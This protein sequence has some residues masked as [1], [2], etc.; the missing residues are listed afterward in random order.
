MND[1]NR[2]ALRTLCRAW[3]DLPFVLVGATAWNHHI[4]LR[5]RQTHDLDV[6]IAVALDDLDAA[7]ARLPGWT[8]DPRVPHRWTSP[9]RAKV[10]VVPAGVDVRPDA[11]LT[12]PDSGAVMDLTG[13][14]L[15]FD[16][17]T[18][19]RL[20]GET[21][22]RVASLPSL[23]VLKAAAWLDRPDERERDL[24][25]LAHAFDEL[26][27]TDDPRRFDDDLLD[28]RVAWDEAGPWV[29]GRAVAAIARAPHRTRL[30]RFLDAVCDEDQ[31]HH[32][33]MRH[34][35]PAHWRADDTALPRRLGAFRRALGV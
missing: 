34:L 23:V 35:G 32:A 29:L 22:V 2:E 8:R 25:D 14:D 5:W 11:T 19:W 1:A 21:V 20:D 27:A 10:D 33:R 15:A 17:H 28:H 9:L 24:A 16:H 12:W 13:L 18:P 4:A 30:A 6:T 31:R 7:R 3:H 26:L